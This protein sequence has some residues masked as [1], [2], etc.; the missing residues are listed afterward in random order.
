[1]KLQA[2][3]PWAAF[4]VGRVALLAWDADMLAHQLEAGDRVIKG[5]L[6]NAC[7]FPGA[8]GVT[9]RAGAS[10]A[11]LMFILMAAKTT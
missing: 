7:P 6:I 2:S 8:C 10:E 4:G 5:V 9:L 11:A 1:L 3:V